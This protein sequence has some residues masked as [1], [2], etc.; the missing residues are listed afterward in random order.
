MVKVKKSTNNADSKLILTVQPRTLFGKKLKKLRREENIPA[1]IFGPDFKSQAVSVNFKDFI[2]VYKTTKETGVVYLKINNDELPVLIKN[3]QRH[4]VKDHILHA[5]FRKIDLKQK[6]L[7]AV[8]I[9]VVGRSEA[10]VQK[11][12]VLLTQTKSLEVEALP[13]NIPQ[14]LEVDIAQL[15]EIN[16]EI[17]VSDLPKSNKYQIKDGLDKIVVSVVEHKE[18]EI[19]P[20]TAPATAPEV[21]TAKPGEEEV[22]EET[23]TSVKPAEPSTKTPETKPS[24]A[25]TQEGKPESAK[26]PEQPK[27]S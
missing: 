20:Q 25:K 24:P 5:D 14:Y 21:I 10:V 17:K 11:A 19:L 2:K 18:E 27:K 3:V 4:P 23:P 8:P 13:I 12:G 22:A 15:K 26:K 6:I 7:T 16:Q 9:K 1:N